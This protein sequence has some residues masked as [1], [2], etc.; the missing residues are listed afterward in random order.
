MQNQILSEQE[1]T[2]L[3]KWWRASNYL[4]AGQLYLLD[5]PFLETPLTREQMKQKIVGHWG[6]DMLP[7][8]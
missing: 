7:F 6:T 5:N 8:R 1:W 4:A 3:D 2:L